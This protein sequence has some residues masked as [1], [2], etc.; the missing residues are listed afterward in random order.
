M[1]RRRR[2]IVR[3]LR[4][5]F[6]YPCIYMMLWVIP[7]VVHCMNYSNYW[8]QHPVFPLSILQVFCMA[9][10]TFCDVFIFCWRERPWRHIPGCRCRSAPPI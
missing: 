8:A 5:L 1:K 6:I 7:F 4:L 2:A 3:Q 9:V 10:M